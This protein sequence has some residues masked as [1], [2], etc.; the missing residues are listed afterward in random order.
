MKIAAFDIGGTSLK[1]GIVSSEGKILVQ[2]KAAIQNSDGDQILAEILRW[3]DLQHGYEGIAISV[4]GYVNP[5]TGLITNGGS[6]RRF[7][8]FNLKIWLEQ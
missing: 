6:I 7:D 4:P 3:L 5:F 1:M 8:H 2:D